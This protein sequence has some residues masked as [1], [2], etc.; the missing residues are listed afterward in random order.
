MKRKDFIKTLAAVCAAP[1]VAA[2]AIASHKK[3]PTDAEVNAVLRS[4]WDDSGDMHSGA[5]YDQSGNGNHAYPP[6]KTKNVV[7]R[8]AGFSLPNQPKTLNQQNDEDTKNT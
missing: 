3:K 6:V 7:N 2:K 4:M 8:E 5:W 1:V